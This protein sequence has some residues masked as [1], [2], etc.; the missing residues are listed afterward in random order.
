MILPA[1]LVVVFD[2]G[3]RIGGDY[4]VIIVVIVAVFFFFSGFHN[5]V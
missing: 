2:G 1:A 4:G 5:V 3:E